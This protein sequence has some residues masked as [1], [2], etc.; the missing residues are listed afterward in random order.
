MIRMC[1]WHPKF[2]GFP[3]KMGERRPYEDKTVVKTACRRCKK[4]LTDMLNEMEKAAGT[5]TP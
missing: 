4:I 3:L 5:R 1:G 2:F